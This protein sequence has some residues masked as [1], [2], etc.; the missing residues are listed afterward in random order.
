MIVS[1]SLLYR[2]YGESLLLF[3]RNAPNFEAHIHK[4][5]WLVASGEVN[6]DLNMALIASEA[7]I[8]VALK[9]ISGFIERRKLPLYLYTEELISKTISKRLYDLGFTKIEQTPF[10]TYCPNSIITA[11]SN[12]DFKII[13]TQ[14]E[15]EEAMTV[16]AQGLEIPIEQWQQVTGEGILEAPGLTMFVAKKN[17]VALSSVTTTQSGSKVGVWAMGTLPQYQRQG[18]STLR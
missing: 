14:S 10:M 15:R 13:A 6:A 8:D 11:P 9:D 18:I 5:A 3:F 17:G 2:L 1:D 7:S 16:A 4:D 12:Y